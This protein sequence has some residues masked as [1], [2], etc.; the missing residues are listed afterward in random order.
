MSRIKVRELEP[1]GKDHGGV[2]VFKVSKGTIDFP[3]MLLDQCVIHETDIFI[4]VEGSNK[5]DKKKGY[6]ID[7][8]TIKYMVD[9][10]PVD[11]EGE[12][13]HSNWKGE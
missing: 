13:S 7:T 3:S 11:E 9:R 12:E 10:H 5:L 8:P 2:L 1:T 4:E 6:Q